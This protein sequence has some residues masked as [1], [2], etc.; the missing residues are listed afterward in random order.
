MYLPADLP[1][2]LASSC[3]FSLRPDVE[4]KSGDW[5]RAALPH[6]RNGR[7]R[8]VQRRILR[9]QSQEGHQDRKMQ[10]EFQR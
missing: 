3:P 7:K 10:S 4:P 5:R 6:R 1:A 9:S 2:D 8:Q